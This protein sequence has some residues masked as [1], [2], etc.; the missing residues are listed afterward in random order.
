MTARSLLCAIGLLAGTLLL[1]S[2]D[3]SNNC[4]CCPD[5]IDPPVSDLYVAWDGG[6]IG[7]D[8]MPIVPPDPVICNAWL[9]LENRNPREAFSKVSVPSADV[10]LVRS[11][12][13]LGTIPLETDWDG[14]LA[15]GRRDTIWFFKS[16]GNEAIFSPPCGERVFVDFVI[17]NADGD[18]K[19]FRPDTLT[20][21]CV[22]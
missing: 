18:A 12:S 14:L 7:A 13:T 1:C 20:F 9:I 6:S 11:D 5:R 16:R 19:V 21:T 3:E 10:I 8:L 15:P 17:R 22:F 4:S 2:C